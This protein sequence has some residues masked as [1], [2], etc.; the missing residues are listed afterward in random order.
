MGAKC[1]NV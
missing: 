1:T